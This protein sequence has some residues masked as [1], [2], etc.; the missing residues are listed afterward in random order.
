MRAEADAA[1]A[2]AEA[3]RSAAEAQAQQSRQLAEQ[4]EREKAELR[5]RLREQLNL[6]LETRETARGLIV[7]LSDV[8]FDVD[9]ATL[10]P[11]AREKLARIA[12]ILAG[13][14]DLKVEIEGHTDS[15][16]S[17][18]YNQRLSERRAAS[19]HAYLMQ[20]GIGQSIVATAGYGE[21][22]PVATNGTAAGRQQNRRVE[23][24]VSGES[25]GRAQ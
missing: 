1:R 12:G 14:P 9:K 20:Q 22:R 24:I 7:N 15:T 19:V 23:L 10:K 13:H 3:A 4:A 5:E 8:L 2:A 25:I 17:D 16:G 21:S 18:E 6:I 11:G